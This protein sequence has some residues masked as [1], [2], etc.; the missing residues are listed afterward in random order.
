M[1]DK[2]FKINTLFVCLRRYNICITRAE[3]SGLTDGA[4]PEL[5][6][7][8]EENA[9]DGV[10]EAALFGRVRLPPVRATHTSIPAEAAGHVNLCPF[11]LHPLHQ[12]R[13]SA[14][15]PAGEA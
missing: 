1:H 12:L 3:T 9:P 6:L 15:A 11:A 14:R 7:G 4:L 8:A 13:L 2:L 5:W 10:P